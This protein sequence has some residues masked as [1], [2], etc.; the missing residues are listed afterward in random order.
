[1]ELV[2]QIRNAVRAL[3]VQDGQ[4]LLLKKDGYAS[5]GIRYALPGG[6]QEAG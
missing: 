1:M 4:V 2:P 5:G 3:I 6:G